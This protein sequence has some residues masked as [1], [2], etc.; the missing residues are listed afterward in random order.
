MPF[1][2]RLLTRVVDRRVR[3]SLFE[4]A[5]GK[6]HARAAYQAANLRLHGEEDLSYDYRPSKDCRPRPDEV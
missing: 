5:G 2:V 3:V 6:G 4:S 1:L